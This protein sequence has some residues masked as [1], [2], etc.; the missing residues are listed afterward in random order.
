[1]G[2]KEGEGAAWT[3][4]RYHVVVRMG[5]S[6]RW[7]APLDCGVKARQDVV[8]RPAKNKEGIVLGGSAGMAESG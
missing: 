8:A 6:R 1:M 4:L 5:P 7:A 3:A 2:K